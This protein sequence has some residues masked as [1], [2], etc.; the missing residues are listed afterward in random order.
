MELLF[1]GCNRHHPHSLH[2]T[3][4]HFTSL[5]FTS[6][7]FASLHFTSL[8]FTSLHFSFVWFV[9]F[10]RFASFARL[11]HCGSI[12]TRALAATSTHPSIQQQ[13][14]PLQFVYSTST[15]TLTYEA[16]VLG[17]NAI[18]NRDIHGTPTS[19]ATWL[20]L[21]VC[22]RMLWWWMHTS[23][24]PCIPCMM[25][26]ASMSMSRRLG[27]CYPQR[28]RRRTRTSTASRYS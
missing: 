2:F 7:H 20:A 28:Q 6:L 15:R 4:L 17:S 27:H 23:C 10:V 24:M 26:S 11:V 12:T 25:S 1:R 18:R 5:H 21:M 16:L 13:R 14:R 3:S 22:L 19:Y 9:W 8:H